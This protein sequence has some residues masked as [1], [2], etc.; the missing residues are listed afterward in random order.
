MEDF[1]LEVLNTEDPSWGDKWFADPVV[2]QEA[3]DEWIR[4]YKF[5]D[6]R[7]MVQGS[8]KNFDPDED[9]ERCDP[10]R[11]RRVR[12]RIATLRSKRPFKNEDRAVRLAL[13]DGKCAF[14]GSSGKLTM[15]HV[16]AISN[17]GL[18]EAENIIP[19]CQSCNS[20][21]NASMVLQ[22]YSQQP[23]FREDRW[24]KIVKHCPSLQLN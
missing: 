14:C 18:H 20:K 9:L 4:I 1:R 11:R 15:D 8:A 12:E 19:A 6:A 2:D 23:F 13:F 24:N 3:V 5:S 21:K 22:W 17:G 7:L 16:I 10:G